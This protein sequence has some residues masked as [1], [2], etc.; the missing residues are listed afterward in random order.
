MP[1]DRDRRDD[2]DRGGGGR[3]KGGAGGG[4]DRD[5]RDRRGGRRGDR[6]HALEKEGPAK[7]VQFKIIKNVEREKAEQQK[8]LDMD[9]PA[10]VKQETSPTKNGIDSNPDLSNF[11]LKVCEHFI[12]NLCLITVI[13]SKERI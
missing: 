13:H 7:D 6:D 3:G 1:R 2:R 4:R 10:L 12:S 5:R 8:Q 11:I 9:F